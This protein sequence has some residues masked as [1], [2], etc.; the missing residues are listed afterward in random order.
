MN[1]YSLVG[2]ALDYYENQFFKLYKEKQK[3]QKPNIW[4]QFFTTPE[5]R[6]ERIDSI[7]K[8]LLSLQVIIRRMKLNS[9]YSYKVAKMIMFTL[10]PVHNN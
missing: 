7:N 5:Q 2:D 3:L 4:M 9:N 1:S 8:K 10:L 6:K